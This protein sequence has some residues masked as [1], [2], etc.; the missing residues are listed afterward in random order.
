MAINIGIW[1]TVIVTLEALLQAGVITMYSWVCLWKVN[2]V[3]TTA[4]V[5]EATNVTQ[6]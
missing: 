4:S 5:K 1:A 2:K 3:M 6:Q